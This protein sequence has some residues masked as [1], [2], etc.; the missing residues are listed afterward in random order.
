MEIYLIRHPTPAVAGGICYGQT[1]LDIT[2]SL[3]E[4]AAVIRR[5]LP[6]DIGAIHSSPL[7]RCTKLAGHLFPSRS[8]V[9]HKELMEIHCGEWEMRRW[10]DLPPEEIDPWMKDFVR[11]RIPGGENYLD[12]HERATGCFKKIL[13]RTDR[14]GADPADGIAAIITHGG[15]IRSIL[16]Y[17]TGTPLAASFDAFTLRVGCVVKVSGREDS[18][19]YEI[20]SNVSREKERHKP[21]RF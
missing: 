15:V 1:D 3:P 5:V 19:Q 14:P 18:L 11:V 9:L 7:Q 21:S 8:V 6:N 17:I 10:D 16:S 2:D 4:E 20:L 13:T 12:L